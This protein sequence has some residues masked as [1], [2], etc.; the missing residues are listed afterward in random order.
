M[1]QEPK[2]QPTNPQRPNPAGAQR[3]QFFDV[4]R[5][6]RTPASPTSRPVLPNNRPAVPD[7]SMKMGAPAV[8][9]GLLDQTKAP[10][11][12]VPQ[13]ASAPAVQPPPAIQTPAPITPQLVR[14]VPTGQPLQQ[15]F[16]PPST[17]VQSQ[18][19]SAEQAVA[20][21][22]SQ[23]QPAH[24]QHSIVSE[25]LAVLAIVLLVAVIIDILLDAEII[26]LPLPHTNF[27]DY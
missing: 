18:Q 14:S 20:P 12:P 15:R 8:P 10:Q 11:A 6:G 27:F 5:P 7:T 19:I 4:V 24:H 17:P 9:P 25:V 13:P 16:I 22:A 2:M 23:P 21:E 3:P 1:E 26:N